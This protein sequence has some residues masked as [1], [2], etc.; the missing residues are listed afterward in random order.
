MAGKPEIL[1]AAFHGKNKI[2][3]LEKLFELA[4]SE[5]LK[6]S[7]K[8]QIETIL[9]SENDFE[10][11][12]FSLDG[13]NIR[14]R[15]G[16]TCSKRWY[17][18]FLENMEPVVRRIVNNNRNNLIDDIDDINNIDNNNANKNNSVSDNNNENFVMKQ[19]YDS[20]DRENNK[21]NK[22]STLPMILSKN[23]FLF[24]IESEERKIK[25]YLEKFAFLR[26]LPLTID[27]VGM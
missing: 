18:H 3:Q 24:E 6:F 14:I 27:L 20:V 10:K 19:D 9:K 23:I 5:Q 4:A 21:K 12:Y 2:L 17:L 26:Y 13:L 7:I 16:Y 11:P 15:R 25:K 22:Y 1:S 8:K